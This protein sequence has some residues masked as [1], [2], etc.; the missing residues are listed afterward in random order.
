[1]SHFSLGNVYLKKGMQAVALDEYSQAI[2][3]A[4]CVPKAHLN[5]GVIF[6]SRNDFGRA[7]EE[8]SLEL[9]K[10][11]VS[12]E[13]HN[14]L[15]VLKRLEGNPGEAL[16]HA[17]EAIQQKVNYPEAYLNKILA[18]RQLSDDSAAFEIA[19]TLATN[20]PDFL[21]G[22]YYLGKMLIERGQLEEARREMEA[23]RGSSRANVVERY[24]LSSI[25]ASQAGYGFQPERLA[26]LANY[27]LGLI[28]VNSGDI[29]KALGYFKKATEAIPNNAEA[30]INLALAYDNQK[31]YIEALEAFGIG[32]GLEPTNAVAY[33]NCGLTLGKLGRFSDAAGFFRKAIELNPGLT[34]AQ[35]K[36]N[37]TESILNR[38]G[39]K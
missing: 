11:H 19:K 26:G 28:E 38:P 36:L 5:R 6:F 31:R 7:E 37:L 32:L 35:E 13:A 20:F 4:P 2:E 12:A 8:F 14:N 3:M 21:S 10:C 22:R 33:Y 34:Q 15:S 24:D 39:Q 9:S 27:E 25:Y 30:W 16:A 1:M 29:E 17:E 18:L 23:V